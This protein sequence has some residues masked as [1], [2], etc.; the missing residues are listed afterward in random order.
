MVRPM[1]TEEL[2]N[3]IQDMLKEKDKL[4]AILDYGTIQK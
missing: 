3:R 2:F 1:T 4:P